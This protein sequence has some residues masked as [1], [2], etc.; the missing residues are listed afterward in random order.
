M[1]MPMQTQIKTVKRS[2]GYAYIP[3]TRSDDLRRFRAL[4]Q[5]SLWK[6]TFEAPLRLA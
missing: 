1:P 5:D 2:F 3:I 4:S 6:R